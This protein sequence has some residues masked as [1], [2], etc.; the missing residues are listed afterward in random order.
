MRRVV[1]NQTAAFLIA[2]RTV[3]VLSLLVRAR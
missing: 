2:E 3:K 1:K